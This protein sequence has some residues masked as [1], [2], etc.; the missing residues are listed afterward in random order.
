MAALHSLE[1]S[2]NGEQ[3]LTLFQVEQMQECPARL[4]DSARELLAA[5]RRLKPASAEAQRQP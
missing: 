2:A 3:V 1:K 5:H 4:L